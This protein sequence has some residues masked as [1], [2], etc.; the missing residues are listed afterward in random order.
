MAYE[1]KSSPGNPAIE[2]SNSTRLTIEYPE[3]PAFIETRAHTPTIH[4]SRTKMVTLIQSALTVLFGSA[5][6]DFQ[7]SATRKMPDR[8]R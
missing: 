2:A 3:E 7:K 4:R 1:S 8:C 5:E 6:S